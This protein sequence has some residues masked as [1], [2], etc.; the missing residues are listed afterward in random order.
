[1]SRE[2][3][4]CVALF[5]ALN[6]GGNSER[7]TSDP[8]STAR[9]KKSKKGSAR[10][11]DDLYFL[12]VRGGHRALN[13]HTH[14]LK[15]FELLFVSEVRFSAKLSGSP[16]KIALLMK[17]DKVAKLCDVEFV[18]NISELGEDDQLTQ[19]ATSQF[20]SLKVPWYN[21][22]ASPSPK[23]R[24]FLK[25]IPLR[26]DQILDIIVV[27]TGALQVLDVNETDQQLSWLANMLEN[28]DSKWRIA[29]GFDPLVLCEQ[30]EGEKVTDVFEPLRSIF[31]KFKVSVAIV[32]QN[33]YL[34]KQG[35]ANLCTRKAGMAYIGNPGP[36]DEEE[37]HK[38]ISS[39]KSPSLFR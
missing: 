32:L 9:L 11:N 10:P 22:N 7:A 39:V 38:A 35:C 31:L 2:I 5:I 33:A 20:S 27:D 28:T 15:Q 19:N 8:I 24:Y 18:V 25:R 4:L 6:I 29:V 14:L 17:M 13:E 34:S 12:S 3:C 16:G 1:M 36:D 30:I 26:H 23:G 21:T 37:S